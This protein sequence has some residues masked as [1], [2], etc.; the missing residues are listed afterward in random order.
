MRQAG[1]EFL[2]RGI[3]GRFVGVGVVFGAPAARRRIVLDV[4][5]SGRC[6]SWGWCIVEGFVVRFEIVAG[7]WRWELGLW[8]PGLDGDFLKV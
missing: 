3:H 4:E 8:R 7:I 2:E 6:S 5:V 1:S